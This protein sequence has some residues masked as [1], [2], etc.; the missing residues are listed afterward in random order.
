MPGC[1]PSQLHYC[2]VALRLLVLL[3][4]AARPD[5]LT[6]LRHE[7]SSWSIQMLA[8]NVSGSDSLNYV[9]MAH[10]AT[11]SSD[12]LGSEVQAEASTMW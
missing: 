3:H 6:Q 7:L 4:K 2:V 5:N 10:S 8:H 9:C 11:P 1:M 12:L